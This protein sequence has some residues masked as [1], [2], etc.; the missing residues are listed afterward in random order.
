MTFKGLYSL[1]YIWK[2]VV[3]SDHIEDWLVVLEIA[4]AKS[5]KETDVPILEALERE[6]LLLIYKPVVLWL[7]ETNIETE[8]SSRN[9][10]FKI[11]ADPWAGV[12]SVII[13]EIVISKPKDS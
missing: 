3:N 8:S 12:E 5:T 10:L 2:R 13:I 7:V 6:E 11:K 1:C 4:D 9:T